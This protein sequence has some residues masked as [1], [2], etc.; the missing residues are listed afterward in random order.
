[1]SV[2]SLGLVKSGL[3]N[4]LVSISP[5]EVSAGGNVYASEQLRVQQGFPTQDGTQNPT[6]ITFYDF[7]TASVAGGGL[8]PHSLQLYGYYDP[9]VAGVDTI[10]E[11]MEVKIVPTALPVLGVPPST[12]SVVQTNQSRPFNWVAPFIGQITGTGA[13]Q[14]VPCAGIPANAVIRFILVGTSA[15]AY[16]AIAPPSAVSVQA[17]TSFTCTLTL[18]AIYDYEVLFA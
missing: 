4:P 16:A 1:M 10:Q 17:Y 8:N 2:A 11:H 14:V 12:T 6:A 18:D 3:D 13:A 15:A 5:Q 9:K 7:Y